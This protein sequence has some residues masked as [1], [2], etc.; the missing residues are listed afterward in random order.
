[1]FVFGWRL[2]WLLLLFVLSVLLRH[3][4]EFHGFVLFARVFFYFIV[5]ASVVHVTLTDAFFVA[6]GYEFD[7]HIL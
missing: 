2:G 7:E 6:L 5:K 1:M 4:V 3:W